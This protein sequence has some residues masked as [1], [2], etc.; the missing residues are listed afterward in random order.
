M[1]AS[2]VAQMVKNLS[3]GDLALIPVSGRSPRLNYVLLLFSVLKY[4][5]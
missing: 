2:L 5:C 3:A 4:M 1:R